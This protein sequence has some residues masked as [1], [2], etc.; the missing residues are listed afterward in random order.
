[1]SQIKITARELIRKSMTVMG[2]LGQGEN[3]SDQEANDALYNLNEIVDKWNTEQLMIP[4]VINYVLHMSGKE[5]YTIGEDLTADFNM[6][7]PL[8]GINNAYFKMTDNMTIP[9]EI[10]SSD[11][12]MLFVDK[13]ITTTLANYI[14]Y[15]A[16]YPLA[17][18]YVYPAA[19][20]GNLILNV[21]SQFE[22]FPDL[23]TV[24]DLPSGYIRALR[25]NLAVDL[26]PEYG[27]QA[28][29][30]LIEQAVGAKS[31]IKVTNSSQKIILMDTDASLMRQSGGFNIWTGGYE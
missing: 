3:P 18:I 17:E 5:K 4:S 15:N 22:I 23:D 31:T 16:V 14:Y 19:T 30:Q 13:A 26:S 29:Q 8:N 1:M 7:R 27:R 12:Y 2:A 20:S 10:L 25:L 21:S 6:K 9:V 28:D 11:Q 24:I